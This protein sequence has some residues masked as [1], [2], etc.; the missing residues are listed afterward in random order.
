[1]ALSIGNNS[2]LS[3]LGLPPE[4]LDYTFQYLVQDKGFSKLSITCH[5]CKDTTDAIFRSHWLRLKLP[6]VELPHGFVDLPSLIGK[7]E[8][9]HPTDFQTKPSNLFH[10]LAKEFAP[11]GA[12][13]PQGKLPLTLDDL[14]ILQDQTIA[15]AQDET[16][17][18]IWKKMVEAFPML[19]D[20]ETASK[21][22][23]ALQHLYEGGTLQKVIGLDLSQ[24]KLRALSPEIAWFTGLQHLR[25]S[26]N[27]LSWLPAEIGSLTKLLSLELSHNKLS[28]L[29]DEI[30]DL[31]KLEGLDLSYNTLSTLPAR[32]GNLTELRGLN[33]SHNMLS[34]LLSEIGKLRQLKDL[35]LSIN[36]LSKLPAK[37]G[38]LSQLQ[39]LN[40]NKNLLSLLPAEIGKLTQLQKLYLYFN[41]L[42]ELPVE[43]GSL[44]QLHILGLNGNPITFIPDTVLNSNIQCIERNEIIINYK[45][46]HS[47]TP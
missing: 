19:P 3:L 31:A 18:A 6:N 13:L 42:N 17:V 16:L 27:Q 21:A 24:L 25:L 38:N 15:A 12:I 9:L 28:I 8:Q 4:M 30:G 26:Y 45:S 32:I 2:S 36:K 1:M 41:R 23:F 40:L 5:Q 20:L 43:I 7:I 33:L 10:E 39:K 46:S 22:R 44:S 11:L 34:E 29:P 14:K 37:I 35:N 47:I